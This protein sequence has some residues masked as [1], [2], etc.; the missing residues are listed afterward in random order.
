MSWRPLNEV[1]SSRLREM[2][3]V[4]LTEYRHDDGSLA[5][6]LVEAVGG[7]SVVLTVWTDWVL[8]VDL[9]EDGVPPSYL[10]PLDFETR[11][12]M[13]GLPAEG[14]VVESVAEFRNEVGDLSRLVLMVNGHRLVAGMWAGDLTL[15][16][17]RCPASGPVS[18]GQ[19][20]PCP[21]CGYLTFA[22]PPGSH[23]ICEVCL[24]EEDPVQLRAPLSLRGANK[25]SLV[26]A[27]RDFR[28]RA[29]TFA[30]DPGWRPVDLG[31]DSFEAQGEWPA[32]LTTLYWWRDTF[33]RGVGV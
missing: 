8:V 14:V 9:E 32:D 29:T 2:S 4:G 28:D 25:V 11:E 18:S 33:W 1:P 6:V 24:W 15:S 27:Q 19:T 31:V 7:A 12:L 16:L 13:P 10:R 5:A 3:V 22:Q 30:R 21:C 26:E 20:H 17:Q 23:E